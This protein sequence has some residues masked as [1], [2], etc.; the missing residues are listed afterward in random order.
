PSTLDIISKRMPGYYIATLD[1]ETKR[2]STHHFFPGASNLN[3]YFSPDGKDIYF[4]SDRDGFRNLYTYNI[5]SEKIF[6]KTQI[7][8]GISG[9]TKLAPA[10]SVAQATGDIAYSYYFGG[11][12]SIFKAAPEDLFNI[13]VNPMFVDLTAGTLPPLNRSVS[14]IIDRNI[15][16]RMG[17]PETPVDSFKVV[18]YR[19]KFKLD[20]I[21]NAGIGVSTGQMG[22][23]MAGGV[24]MLF[25]DIVGANLFHVGV[26]LNGEIYDFGGQITYINQKNRAMWGVTAS[27]I[28]YSYAF[29]DRGA[30]IISDGTN[31]Y[32]ADTLY[33]YHFRIFESTVGGLSQLPLS[34]TRR[35]EAGGYLT[36]YNYRVDVHSHLYIDGWYQGYSREKGDAPEGYALQRLNLAYVVDNSSFGIASPMDGSRQRFQVDKVFGYVNYWGTLF[37]YRKYIFVKPFSFAFK[38]FYYGRHGKSFGFIYPLYLGYPWLIRGYDN[39]S[40]SNQM[41]IDGPKIDPTQLMGNQMALVNFEIRFPFTGPERLTAF[42]SKFFF[43]E[44]ALFADAGVA[45]DYIRTAKLRE[46]FKDLSALKDL[47]NNP[48]VSSVGIS[49]RINVF[50]ALILEPFYA[51][52]FQLGGIDAVTFG[53]NF[54][55]GW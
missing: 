10:F 32:F 8:T 39:N 12:Y 29:F 4:L 48:F 26:A 7:L 50:G 6:Q 34:K 52:P 38:S 53:L 46:G 30:G 37:D 40:F 27:H 2:V 55:P 28:P 51:I 44:L 54:T 14:G 43:T 13:E 15:A 11:K 24:E 19:P 18:K 25:S 17:Q 3:P 1:I 31:D 41:N 20:Y 22:T 9:I 36:W 45:F 49:L 33:L 47:T 16:K 21:S 35:I 5:E 23:G 42:K